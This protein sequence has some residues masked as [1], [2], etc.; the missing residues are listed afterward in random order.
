MFPTNQ[1]FLSAN[2]G[3]SNGNNPCFP[4][5]L[6]SAP[7]S[8][9]IYAPYGVVQVGQIAIVP[10]V[11][12]WIALNLISTSTGITVNWVQLASSSG[13]ILAIVGTT[14]QVTATTAAG[15]TTLTLPATVVAPG[16]LASTT[17]LTAGTGLTVTTGGITL[18]GS[19][20][21]ITTNPV[22]V[23]AGASPQVANGHV[24]QVTFSGVSIAAGASQTFTITNSGIT[25]AGTV[26]EYSWYGA[27]AGS[28]LSMANVVNSAGSSAIT[29]TNGTGASTST[30]NITFIFQVLN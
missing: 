28:A 3:L 25:G 1:N 24:G 18:L 14:N 10:A 23:A 6:T 30:A 9:T 4:M 11:G 13:D 19:G 22:I 15:T 16:S 20:Q 5:Y 29:M 7:T 26:I 27:T 12:V 21:G 8:Q 17:T 2:A